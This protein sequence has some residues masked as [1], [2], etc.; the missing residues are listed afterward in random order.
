MEKAGHARQEGRPFMIGTGQ[1]ETEIRLTWWNG[2]PK[3]A[4][5]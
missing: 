2:F 3:R 5:A 4:I 1:E